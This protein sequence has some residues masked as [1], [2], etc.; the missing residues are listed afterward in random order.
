[1]PNPIT[2]LEE[3]HLLPNKEATIKNLE[4]GCSQQLE[5]EEI[6]MPADSQ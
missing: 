6:L 4:K 5:D 2:H 1:M 3:E